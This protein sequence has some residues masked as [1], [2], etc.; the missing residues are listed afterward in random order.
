[1]NIVLQF[2][3][4]FIDFLRKFGEGL[5]VGVKTVCHYSARELSAVPRPIRSSRR[6]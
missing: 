2:F 3:S 4:C 6:I 5:G 1:M